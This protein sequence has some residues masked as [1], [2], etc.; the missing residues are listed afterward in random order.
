MTPLPPDVQRI[1]DAIYPAARQA[2]A[3]Q[4]SALEIK[5]FFANAVLELALLF[6]F[7]YSG[8]PARLRAALE[9]RFVN[10]SVAAAAFVTISYAGLAAALLPIDWY[11]GFVVLH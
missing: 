10:S 1:V 8:A 6:G 2:V 7:Y 4:L 11:A 5:I 3:Q 9:R